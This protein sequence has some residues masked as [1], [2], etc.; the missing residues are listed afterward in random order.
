MAHG[1]PATADT[2][3]MSFNS[4]ALQTQDEAYTLAYYLLG[5]E[6]HAERATQAAFEQLHRHARMEL[7]RFRLE[8]LRRVVDGCRRIGQIMPDRSA[9]RSTLRMVAS[10]DETIQRLLPLNDGERFVVVLVDILG[11][12]YEEAAQVLGSSKKE[13]SRNLAKARLALS[14]QE[15][16][17]QAFPSAQG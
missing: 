3:F 13:V 5:D 12:S 16:A 10:R 14:E 4:L 17:R 1:L 9:L 15:T 11:L 6:R 2:Q 7:N 8:V